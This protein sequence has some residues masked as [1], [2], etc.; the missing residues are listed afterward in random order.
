MRI[1]TDN[2]VVGLRDVRSNVSYTTKT[3]VSRGGNDEIDPEDIIYG[4]YTND[5]GEFIDIIYLDGDILRTFSGDVTAH[6]VIDELKILLRDDKQFYVILIKEV[7]AGFAFKRMDINEIKVT[8]V[9]SSNPPSC[10]WTMRF[11]DKNIRTIETDYQSYFT[12]GNTIR[13]KSMINTDILDRVL[14]KS[15]K[16]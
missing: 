13:P 4:E 12:Y 15:N 8:S 7:K 9:V 6:P 10:I 11:A 1:N 3:R 5:N 2:T 16:R 14:P